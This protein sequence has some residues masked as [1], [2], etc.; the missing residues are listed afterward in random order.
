VAPGEWV[1]V[2]G[3]DKL[4]EGGK[5]QLSTAAADGRGAAGDT[6]PAG[7]RAGAVGSDGKPSGE[8]R[9]RRAEGAQGG[10]PPS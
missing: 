6:A 3:V 7:S 8:R 9:R 2:D 5:V 1:V 10:G 4:R